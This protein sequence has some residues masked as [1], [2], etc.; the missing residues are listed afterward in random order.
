MDTALVVPCYNEEGRLQP[1]R[2]VEFIE[3]CQDVQ[4]FLVDDGSGDGTWDLLEGIRAFAPDRVTTMKLA[5]NGGKAEAV[6]FGVNEAMAGDFRYAAYWD[7]DLATP[8]SLVSTFRDT[9]R[10]RP[11]CRLV[12][13][14]R[15]RL[16]GRDIQRRLFRHYLGRVFSTA[17]SLA[18]RLPV[19]DTQCGAKM[20][21]ADSDFAEVFSQPFADPWLFDVEILFRLSGLWGAATTDRI[22]ELPL[23]TWRDV[24]GS[25]V[26]ARDG[27][28]AAVG[29]FRLW[30]Q[31]R[32][33]SRD[34]HG[35]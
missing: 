16:L 30:V 34:T 2:F 32:E 10:E 28:R 23:P 19:Y 7:A 20:F 15:V 9:F 1:T 21:A 29:L 5:R 35:T 25:K 18:L 3:D 33:R 13:G 24:G 8:L 26:K 27:L 31:G 11:E 12:M 4:L 14:S 22:V 17:A 6:R